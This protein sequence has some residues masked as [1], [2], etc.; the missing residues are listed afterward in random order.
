MGYEARAK[1]SVS[2]LSLEGDFLLVIFFFNHA[3]GGGF[4]VF[5][6]RSMVERERAEAQKALMDGFS[7]SLCLHVTSCVDL[8]YCLFLVCLISKHC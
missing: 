4:L 2:S 7:F 6:Q 3:E 1:Q 5:L 8:C